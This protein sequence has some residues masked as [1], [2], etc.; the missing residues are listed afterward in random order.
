MKKKWKQLLFVLAALL[1]LTSMPVL[2]ASSPKL[3]ATK[4]NLIVGQTKTLNVLN[5]QKSVKWSSSNTKVATVSNGKVKAISAGTATIKAKTGTKTLSCKV[6]VSNRSSKAYGVSFSNTSGGDFIK[7]VS[8][9]TIKFKLKY[10]S[11]AVKVNI[12]TDTGSVVYTKTFSQCKENKPYT[13]TWNGKTSRGSY[14]TQGTYKVVIVAGNT[15]T[16][17]E[18]LKFYTSSGFDGG[19]GSKSNPYKVSTLSQ[20]TKV[21]RYNGRYFV[22]TAD[23]NGDDANFNSLFTVDNPFTGVYDGNNHTIKNL[24]F[25]RSG[26]NQGLFASVAD[27]GV[28]K[29]VRVTNFRFIQTG[30]TT[31][32][33][34]YG[35]IA[36]ENAGTILNCHAQ[37]SSMIGTNVAA[38]RGGI[39]GYNTGTIQQC[40]LDGLKMQFSNYSYNGACNGGIVGINYMGTVRDCISKNFSSTSIMGWKVGGVVA[41]CESGTVTGC[42]VE[43]A[44]LIA[45][46]EGNCGSVIGYASESTIKDCYD[47]SGSILT[48]IGYSYHCKI[49]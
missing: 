48:L 38:Q 5:N 42:S 37:D 2:A 40:T 33:V 15:K 4:L 31:Y 20:L 21:T 17:S 10:T 22:Q 28:V 6:V 39:C 26:A 49:S 19:D 47:D 1:I 43:G 18:T 8:K 44:L 24:Y 46:T 9:A 23:I 12:V 25:R 14:V 13:F 29:N 45:N 3:N 35:C 34:S 7:G 30:D 32:E 16:T 36:G 41:Y 27:K 11:T